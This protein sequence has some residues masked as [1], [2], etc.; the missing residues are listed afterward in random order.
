MSFFKHESY[1]SYTVTISNTL[2]TIKNN[3]RRSSSSL[4]NTLVPQSK[5]FKMRMKKKEWLSYILFL[6]Y[7]STIS[8]VSISRMRS[9]FPTLFL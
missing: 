3:E 5:V 8:L 2:S 4:D 6:T 1:F 7:I 9:N